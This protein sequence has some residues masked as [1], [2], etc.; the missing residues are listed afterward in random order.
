MNKDAEAVIRLSAAAVLPPVAGTALVA[1][2]VVVFGE[3]G[4]TLFV[5][6]PIFLGFTSTAIYAPHGDKSFVRCF[7]AGLSS[8]AAIAVLLMVTAI[9]G[10]ICLAMAMP[11]AVPLMGIGSFI[12]YGVTRQWMNDKTAAGLSVVLFLLMPVLMGFEAS[13]RS[14]PSLYTVSTTVEIDAPIE[15]VWKNVVTFSHI[16]APPEGILNLGF[17][18]PTDAKIEG[19]G[20][21][22]V[23]YC[24][25]TTGPF[26]EPITDWQEP[27]FLAFDVAK[28]PAPMIEMTPYAELHA[29]HLQYIRSRKGQFRLYERDGRTVVEGT[30]FY[31]HDIAPDAYW[32]IFSDEV[33]HKIHVRVLNHIKAVSERRM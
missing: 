28:Q 4:W 5:V 17:A 9:E 14:E 10:L 31:T 15:T 6:L 13:D 30:T 23:R 2:S 20:V 16:D 1:L 7:L 3:Y 21:G 18:Y 24:N 32:N 27:N 26:V 12:A 8:L 33:I 29:A 19:Q 11:L 22:A 25:F